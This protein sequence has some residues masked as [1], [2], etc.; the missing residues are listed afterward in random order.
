LFVTPECFYQGSTVL[1]TKEKAKAW[2]P[3]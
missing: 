1:K 3:D 2:I